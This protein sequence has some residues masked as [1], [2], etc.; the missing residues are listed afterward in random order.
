MSQWTLAGRLAGVIA[1][2]AASW[3]TGRAAASKE[4]LVSRP[5]AQAAAAPPLQVGAEVVT[6]KNETRRVALDGGVQLYLNQNTKARYVDKDSLLVERGEI[7]VDAPRRTDVKFTVRTAAETFR[8]ANGKFAV[9]HGDQAGVV[10]LRGAVAGESKGGAF[11]V[12]AGQQRLDGRIVPLPRASHVLEWTHDLLAEALLVPASTHA[13][14]RL[15]AKDPQGQ[16]AKI[17]LRKFHI[18]VHIEDGFAR[19][20]IDQ[21]YFNH[22][23]SP[24]EG[25]FFFPLPADA[26]LSRLAMYVDGALREGGMAERDFARNVYESIRYA[27]RDPALLEWVDGTTFKMRVFPMEPRTEKR[28]ILSYT[29]RLPAAYGQTQYRFPAGH[30]LQT[31]DQWSFRARLVHG[32]DAEWKSPSHEMAGKRDGNDLVIEG[33]ANKSRTDRDVVLHLAEAKDTPA[34][35][36]STARHEGAEYLM[37]R[38]RPTLPSQNLYG[39]RHWAFLFESSGDRDPLLARAQIEI[40]RHLLTQ[41]NPDDTFQVFA[42]GT[43]VKSHA[44]GPQPPTVDAI[45][46]AIAFLESSHLI[47]AFDLGTALDRVKGPSGFLVHVGSGFAALGERRADELIKKIP[48][49]TQYVGVGV[50]R[51]WDRA[52]MKRAA[53]KTGG[54]FTQINPDEPL[55]WRSFELFA[56][57]HTPRLLDIR[58]RAED[59]LTED[60]GKPPVRA[61]PSFLTMT[62]ACAQGD[63]IVALTRVGSPVGQASS[64]PQASGQAG[65]LPH[66][67][68]PTRVRVTGT[69][70]GQP[71]DE[72]LDLR[73]ARPEADYLPRMWAKL[74]IDRLLAA[75]V[76]KNREAIVGLSKAMYVM[77]PFTSLLVL[78]N[79]DMYTQY[80]VDRGRKDH[81]AM[82]PC[83]EKIEVVYEPLPGEP[84]LRNLGK[85]EPPAVVAKSV[86]RR[87][88]NQEL[89]PQNNPSGN[90]MPEDSITPA[91]LEPVKST[92][93]PGLDSPFEGIKPTSYGGVASVPF[94]LDNQILQVL[95][96][97]RK[98]KIGVG[99]TDIDGSLTATGVF[100]SA[101]G[102]GRAGLDRFSV[103]PSGGFPGTRDDN[104]R[105]E[106]MLYASEDL[107]QIR[108]EWRRFWFTD[109]PDH[110]APRLIDGGIGGSSELYKPLGFSVRNA[111]PARS[112]PGLE[113]S[114]SPL[115]GGTIAGKRVEFLE[116]TFFETASGLN[117]VPGG[118]LFAA[119]RYFYHRPNLKDDARYF[120]DLVAYAPGMNSSRSDVLAVVEAEAIPSRRKAGQ[121]DAAARALFSKATPSGWQLFTVD[122]EAISFDGAGRYV[123][124]HVLPLGIRERV[125]CNGEAL[126][127]LY[128]QLHIGARRGVS[129]FHR[130]DWTA[131][132]PWVLPAIDDLAH[133]ADVRTV[134][135][136]TVALMPHVRDKLTET[137]H[138]HYLFDASG[139]F[140]EKRWIAAPKQKVLVRQVFEP[141]GVV[142]TFDG[143]GKEIG[144]LKGEL[145]PVTAPAFTTDLQKLVV[146]PLPYRPAEHVKR[147]LKAEKKSTS[148]LSLAEGLPLF[149]SHFGAGDANGALDVFKNCFARREQRP[150]G[151]YVLL[152]AL[153]QNLDSQNLDVVSE[154]LDDPLAQYLALHSSPVLRQHASQWAVQS[155]PWGDGFLGQFGLTHAL[156]QRWS[157]DKINKLAPA[158]LNAE[159]AKAL[160]FIR[161]HKESPFAWDLLCRLQDRTAAEAKDVHKQLAKAFAWFFDDPNLAYAARYEAARSASRAGNTAAAREQFVALYAKAR[162]GGALPAIDGDF[163]AALENGDVWS[164]TLQQTA[165]QWIDAKRRPAV[166]ALAWQVW[167]LEDHVLANALHAR[168]L[169]GIDDP[170]DK[171]QMQRAVLD[172]LWNSNQ[173]ESADELLAEMLADKD[174]AQNPD[175]WR[176]GVQYADH[177]KLN[178]RSLECLQKALDAEFPRLPEVVNLEVVASEYGRLLEHYRRLAEAM[179]ILKTTPTA[180][181]TAN[182]VRT[183]DRW[184]ALHPDNEKPSDMAADI[185]RLLADKTL[186]WDYQ[187]TPLARRPH[188][189]ESWWSLAKSL[190]TSGD[191]ELADIAYQAAEGAEPTN[192]Q[193]LWDRAQ[194]LHRLGRTVA[195]QA[196]VRRIAD[197]TW[198]PR[199]QGLV[200]QA[201]TQMAP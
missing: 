58:V 109:M 114:F 148:E 50:G 75:D 178:A 183:A 70:L 108:D 79:D 137:V 158:Q 166:L 164:K 172:F 10:V 94:I 6:A 97:A 111:A 143:D 199:F 100:S 18:D 25:T 87:P 180:E 39:K 191:L 30:S 80:K 135:E 41:L 151:L 196:L 126:H 24:L 154:H 157:T 170:K 173:V 27:N 184:R 71:I 65:S 76:L 9:R 198:Q 92:H 51:R 69:V 83:P 168:A 66:V 107:R 67:K 176:L 62:E 73:A 190:L 1:V 98:T 20:T 28:I 174:N 129:R 31:V 117:G 193:I 35:R 116:K 60:G 14:G 33:A 12:S 34:V 194:N 54:H 26:S 42:A 130:L 146:L 29:Q 150:L 56:T 45:G 23:S 113:S 68:L 161:K 127:H 140:A 16:E 186:A 175:L 82:Y 49:G 22:E 179:V 134:G 139:R 169:A 188:E 90:I 77:S 103:P 43:R 38:F 122:G 123:Y 13:G 102:S 81:W 91:L 15:L 138:I 95:I 11:E 78:E 85:K 119:S 7:M 104:V 136:R 121:I 72:T 155:G 149:A 5:A 192:P 131:Q 118:E 59:G 63:E 55:A 162:D 132:M 64:L 96:G 165:K 88:R 115:A 89:A 125:E 74:E 4:Y 2:V 142:R 156:L 145:R 128:P 141:A 48:Q 40:I 47:G 86:I 17:T 163:R 201:R 152:A 200:N 185:L 84:D 32:A 101:A 61:T 36:V 160:E 57:L 124:E 93:W 44:E 159:R 21:T 37:L 181:F 171:H 144:V 153:G 147:Q 106:Q 197:G 52:F 99:F 167:Q 19:T 53:E 112:S 46:T 8:S 195:A 187:T 133:G 120:F 182:V 3:F 105:M 177:R 189:S 110:L